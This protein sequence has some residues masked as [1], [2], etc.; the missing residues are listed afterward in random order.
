M[1]R[2]ALIPLKER[3]VLDPP[4]FRHG[5]GWWEYDCYVWIAKKHC[6]LRKRWFDTREEAKESLDKAIA[7]ERKEAE[8]KGLIKSQKVYEDVREAYLHNRIVKDGIASSSIYS[9][10]LYALRRFFDPYYKGMTPIEIFTEK[11][12]ERFY[13]RLL[14][15]KT[16][17]GDPLSNKNANRVVSTYSYMLKY[18][19]GMKLIDNEAYSICSFIVEPIKRKEECERSHLKHTYAMEEKDLVKL[20][21]VLSPDTIDGVLFRLLVWSGFRLGEALGL[22]PREIDFDRGLIYKE[23]IWGVGPDGKYTRLKRTKNGSEGEY[24]VSDKVLALL[25]KYISDYSIPQDRL[26]FCLNKDPKKA[27]C[28]S[29]FRRRLQVACETAG[30]PYV[31][32]HIARH[33]FCTNLS[34]VATNSPQDMKIIESVTGHKFETD[35]GTYVHTKEERT[36][37]LVNKI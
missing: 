25:R 21:E 17:F 20:L 16:R 2:K 23:Y 14:N 15:A 27:L 13:K 31:W 8:Q 24:I 6:H 5:V 28:P 37:E 3:D 10:D 7:K 12:A 26:L 34:M 18:C 36:R 35:Q 32:P 11:E 33:T 22:S 30:I 9:K 4:F 29:A 19:K 1:S